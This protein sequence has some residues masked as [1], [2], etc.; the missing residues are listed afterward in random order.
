MPDSASIMIPMTYDQTCETF[1]F[2]WRNERFVLAV[3]R[4]RRGPER[5]GAVGRPSSSIGASERV[6]AKK[7]RKSAAKALESLA[8]VNSCAGARPVARGL[9]ARPVQL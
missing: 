1:R 9:R 4:P 2:A 7:L 5:N 3:F 8:P 6:A